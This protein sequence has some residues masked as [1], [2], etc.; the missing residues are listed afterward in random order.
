MH[1]P[2]EIPL[3][4]EKL[5]ASFTL[6]DF[7]E[8]AL[9]KWGVADSAEVSFRFMG[10]MAPHDGS[11]IEQPVAVALRG[12]WKELDWGTWKPGE[13]ASLK[14][15]ADVTYYQYSQNSQILIEIDALNYVYTVDGVDQLAQR[16]RN[17]GI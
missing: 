5:K 15:T 8:V 10:S 1:A 9:R 11:G 2:V 17:L 12:T 6:V 14:I 3:G 13:V 4:L 16:R 7:S